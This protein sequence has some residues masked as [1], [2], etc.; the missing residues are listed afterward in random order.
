MSGLA[1][2]RRQQIVD[3]AFAAFTENGYEQ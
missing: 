3:A 2:R 1:D